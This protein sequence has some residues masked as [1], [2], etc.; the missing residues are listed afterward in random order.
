MRWFV[1]VAAAVLFASVIWV[2]AT[3]TV[4]TLRNRHDGGESTENG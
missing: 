2:V 3:L 1:L 4:T